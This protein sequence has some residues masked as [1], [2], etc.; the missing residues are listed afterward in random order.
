MNR[1]LV[2]LGMP[3]NEDRHKVGGWFVS[4]KLDGI[5]CLWDG[6]MSR[7]LPL[8][9]FPLANTKT[10]DGLKNKPKIKSIKCTGLWSRYGNPIFAPDWFLDSLPKFVLDGELYAGRQ[11]FQLCKSITSKHVPIDDEWEQITYNAYAAPPLSAL[12]EPGTVSNA[13][14][15]YKIEINAL[16]ILIELAD[17]A[18]VDSS[19][20]NTVFK[21]QYETLKIVAKKNRKR[22][23]H[24]VFRVVEQ[25]ELPTEN[26]LKAIDNELKKVLSHDQPGE[27]LMLRCPNTLYVPRRVRQLLKVK[28]R[29]TDTAII[30]GFTRGNG[31]YQKFLGSIIVDYKGKPLRLSGMVDELRSLLPEN[32]SGDEIKETPYFKI[33]MKVSFEYREL[34]TKGVPKEAAFKKILPN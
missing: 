34:T 6:G 25:K 23:K 28:P 30:T 16:R 1:E 18:R 8:S 20:S 11:S 5:R 17:K 13:N 19:L 24:S 12:A 32:S 9:E 27:G 15:K 29:Y 10:V 3:F 26:Y 21:D 22:D 14:C 4:E 33:G 7:G 31:K 2:T